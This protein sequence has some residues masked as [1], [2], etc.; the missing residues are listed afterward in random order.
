MIAEKIYEISENSDLVIAQNSDLPPTYHFVKFDDLFVEKF[1]V[2]KQQFRETLNHQDQKIIETRA[3]EIKSRG[4]EIR[5]KILCYISLN[6]DPLN[7][8]HK[9]VLSD[10]ACHNQPI[11]KKHNVGGAIILCETSDQR[12]IIGSR[13]VSRKEKDSDNYFLQCPCGFLENYQIEGESAMDKLKKNSLSF[14]EFIIENG[15]RELKEEI[16]PFEDHEITEK[17]LFGGIFVLREWPKKIPQ[18]PDQPLTK[19]IANFKSFIVVTKVSLSFEE[20]KELRKT[21]RKPQDF[22]EI[23][24][25]D[26]LTRHEIR[27]LCS[28]K[29]PIEIVKNFDG[30][31]RKF[32]SEHCLV[33]PIANLHNEATTLPSPACDSIISSITLAPN[34]T[35]QAST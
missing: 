34:K 16:L 25:I 15:I 31:E 18:E 33:L 13:D 32:I 10:Y 3:N 5:Q 14:E 2:S 29:K 12:L 24:L 20:I 21:S 7:Q 19:K 6:K 8:K 26:G 23:T 35:K 4:E 1:S 28:H 27:E 22:D 17:K 30:K 11:S 9:I